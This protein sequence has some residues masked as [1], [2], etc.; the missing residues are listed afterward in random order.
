MKIAG[1]RV[2]SQDGGTAD[3]SGMYTA[4]SIV[5]NY[6][7]PSSGLETISISGPLPESVEAQVCV[8]VIMTV[9]PT[10][11]LEIISLSLPLF[12]SLPLS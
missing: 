10:M 4:D 3:Q 11:C 9:A 6:K 12:L 5:I 1:K 2:F 8:V 7:N